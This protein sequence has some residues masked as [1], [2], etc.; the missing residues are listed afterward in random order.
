MRTE[1]KVTKKAVLS[2]VMMIWVGL[3]M[4]K[5]V[6]FGREAPHVKSDGVSLSS[7]TLRWRMMQY[8]RSP[9]RPQTVAYTISLLTVCSLTISVLLCRLRLQ[10]QSIFSGGGVKP[11]KVKRRRGDHKQSEKEEG[12]AVDKCSGSSLQCIN[13]KRILIFFLSYSLC[14]F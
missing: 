6:C 13:K 9:W 14:F 5:W 2:F 1:L 8:E 10:P 11:V 3:V 4:N 12:T 7:G